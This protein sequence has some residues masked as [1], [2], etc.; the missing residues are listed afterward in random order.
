MKKIIFRRI[1]TFYN[2]WE[3]CL[4]CA[5]DGFV[6]VVLKIP[7]RETSDN[8]QEETLLVENWDLEY[9]CQRI[10]NSLSCPS[11]ACYV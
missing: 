5:T 8:L 6:G 4:L 1:L 7:A 10:H 2:L 11:G 9:N 3:G